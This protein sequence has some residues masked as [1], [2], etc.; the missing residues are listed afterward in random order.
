MLRLFSIECVVG[1]SVKL[2]SIEDFQ[3]VFVSDTLLNHVFFF[4]LCDVFYLIE[5][6]RNSTMQLEY[7]INDLSLL[8]VSTVRYAAQ[9]DLCT[10]PNGKRQTSIPRTHPESQSL[11]FP[12]YL[13]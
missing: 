6:L 3:Q 12:P 4:K 7:I 1:Y 5:M 11:L 10:V 8:E 13:T 2:S 9:T